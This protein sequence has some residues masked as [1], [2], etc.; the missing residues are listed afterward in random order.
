[1]LVIVRRKLLVGT[2]LGA[3]KWDERHGRLRAVFFMRR[4]SVFSR[5]RGCRRRSRRLGL[6]GR[7]FFLLL[8]A[9]LLFERVSELVGGL[10]EFSNAFAER[11]AEL[12]QLSRT[13]DDQSDHENDDQLRHADRTKHTSLLS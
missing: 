5:R 6:L 13:E 1:I 3:R 8:D 7:R 4:L 11:F 12:R 2:S 10:F 9:D